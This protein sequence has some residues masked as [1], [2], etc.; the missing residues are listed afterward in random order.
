MNARYKLDQLSKIQNK[1]IFFDTN[2]ILYIFWPTVSPNRKWEISAYS[3]FFADCLKSKHPLCTDAWVLSEFVNRA[4][5]LEHC[6]CPEPNF[7]AYRNSELGQ[8]AMRDVQNVLQKQIL[9][10]FDIV[11]KEIT[12]NDL[13]GFKLENHDIN[14]LVIQVTCEK[15]GCVLATHDAD[16]SLSTLDIISANQRLLGK[17]A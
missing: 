1:A 15:Y 7:K 6:K 4:I 16:F 3:K 10:H 14:D 5:R 2:L 11:G 17:V 12:K 13:L 8:L 9:K